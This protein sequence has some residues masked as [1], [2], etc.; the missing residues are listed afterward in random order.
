MV[1]HPGVRRRLSD[2]VYS[3]LAFRSSESSI[4]LC[5]QE[6][7]FASDNSFGNVIILKECLRTMMDLI[8]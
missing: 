2:L 8:C 5:I 1:A 4:L 7:L 6:S 3:A